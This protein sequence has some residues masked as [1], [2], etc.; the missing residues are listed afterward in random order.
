MGGRCINSSLLHLAIQLSWYHLLKRLLFPHWIVL[1]SLFE[2]HLTT[3]VRVYLCILHSVPMNNMFFLMTVPNSLDYYCFVKSF[4]IGIGEPSSFVILFHHSF[5]YP[6][7][8]NFPFEFQDQFL[9][10]CQK[11]SWNFGDFDRFHIKSVDLFE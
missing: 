10:F 3:N 11:G 2:N 9:H 7:S 1:V 8:L 4:V 5:D 6:G